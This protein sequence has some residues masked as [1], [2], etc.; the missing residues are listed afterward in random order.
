MANWDSI[1]KSDQFNSYTPEQQSVVR[2]GYFD[3]NIATNDTYKAFSPDQQQTVRSNWMEGFEPKRGVGQ[4]TQDYVSSLGK[5]L[6]GLGQLGGRAIDVAGNILPDFDGVEDNNI[7]DRA[8]QRIEQLYKG[9]EEMFTGKQSAHF[10]KEQE[11]TYGTGGEGFFAS[12]LGGEAWKSPEKVAGMVVESAPS[13]IL[14]MATGARTIQGLKGA[15]VKLSPWIMG[16]IGSAIGEGTMS[17][18]ETGKGIYDSMMSDEARDQFVTTPEYKKAFEETG[19]ETKARKKVAGAMA[20]RYGLGVGALTSLTGVVSGKFLDDIIGE[21]FKGNLAQA[22]AKGMA[23]EA[24]EEAVQSG[25]EQVAQ[26][27]IAGEFVDPKVK[28]YNELGEVMTSGAIAGGVMGAGIT[29]FFYKKPNGQLEEVPQAVREKISALSEMKQF[30]SIVQSGETQQLDQEMF[31]SVYQKAVTLQKQFPKDDNVSEAIATLNIER[32][33]RLAGM[34][35]QE[36]LD[37]EVND[38]MNSVVSGDER[39]AP[40]AEPKLS[41][42]EI[43]AQSIYGETTQIGTMA[44]ELAQKNTNI[45]NSVMN[46]LRQENPIF[47]PEEQRYFDQY[48]AAQEQVEK[49]Q[50]EFKKKADAV[51]AR[52]GIVAETETAVDEY[53]PEV[54]RPRS[55]YDPAVAE[56][57]KAQRTTE[58]LLEMPERGVEAVGQVEPLRNLSPEGEIAQQEYAKADEQLDPEITAIAITQA[59]QIARE[60]PVY[61]AIQDGRSGGMIN[62]ETLSQ[63]FAKEGL[64]NKYPFLFSNNGKLNID[65]F[66]SEQG[67]EDGNALIEDLRSAIPMNDEIKKIADSILAEQQVGAME[68]ADANIQERIKGAQGKV[69]KLA[70]LVDGIR[71][72]EALDNFSEQFKAQQAE[73]PELQIKGARRKINRAIKQKRYELGDTL[74]KQE[75]TTTEIKEKAQTGQAT[76]G[77]DG[78]GQAI[79]QEEADTLRKQVSDILPQYADEIDTSFGKISARE[80]EISSETQALGDKIAV[81]VS[82]NMPEGES[83]QFETEDEGMFMFTPV[84]GFW[85]GQE[86]TLALE[87]LS[88]EALEKSLENKREEYQDAEQDKGKRE[89]RTGVRQEDNGSGVLP[90]DTGKEPKQPKGKADSGQAEV[91]R[92]GMARP[93]DEPSG[94]KV[95]GEDGRAYILEDLAQAV[96]KSGMKFTEFASEIRKKLGKAYG[97]VRAKLQVIF[98][99]LSKPL[100]D[101]V[102]AVGKDVSISSVKGD[103]TLVALHNLSEQNILYAEDN[104]DGHLPVPSLAITKKETPLTDFGEISLIGDKDLISPSSESKVFGADAYTPRYPNVE[105]KINYEEFRKFS[106]T[107]EESAKK[108]GLG[109]YLDSSMMERDRWRDT[110]SRNI[111]VQSA[112]LDSIGKLPRMRMK[113]YSFPLAENNERLLT[114]AGQDP[115]ELASSKEFRDDIKLAYRNQGRDLPKGLSAGGF[116]MDALAHQASGYTKGK[117][118]DKASNRD[119]VASRMDSR[120]N[121]KGIKGYIERIGKDIIEGQQIFKGFNQAGSRKLYTPATLDNIVKI[122]KKNTR[123]GESFNYGLNSIKAMKTPQFK[124]LKAIK[125]NEDRLLGKDDFQVVWDEINDE[126]NDLLDSVEPQGISDVNDAILSASEGDFQY[127][128]DISKQD[129]AEFLQNLQDM[130]SKYFEVKLNR[131]VGI[132]EFS[133]AVVP[134][135]TSK[136]TISLLKDKGL[137]V[138]YYKKGDV[139]DRTRAVNLFKGQMFSKATKPLPTSQQADVTA[140]L[141]KTGESLIE[142][143]KL[144]VIS[145]AQLEAMTLEDERLKFAITPLFHG[146]PKTDIEKFS[147]DFAG[148]GGGQAFGHGVYFT[149]LQSVAEMYR[150]NVDDMD[151]VRSINAE[152][153][154]VLKAMKPYESGEYGKFTEQKGYDLKNKYDSLI[155]K[156]EKLL[157]KKG[158]VYQVEVA[159]NEEEFL[160]WDKPL[161]EQSDYIQNII[162]NNI[163]EHTKT[164]LGYLESN[165]KMIEAVGKNELTG[166]DFYILHNM[167]MKGGKKAVSEYFASIGIRGNKAT[168]ASREGSIY[169]LFDDS[170]IK[171][172]AKYS[173]DG[174]IEAFYDPNTD[175]TTLVQG[176]ISKGTAQNILA[177]EIGVHARSLGFNKTDDF[178]GILSMLNT[179]KDKQTAEGK[180]IRDAYDSVPAD[181]P[182][183]LINEEALAYLVNNSPKI[184]IVR[185]LIAK[186]KKFL[187]EH[188]FNADLLKNID[189]QALA[190]SVVKREARRVVEQ[191]GV[192]R[193]IT[194][195]EGVAFS[196]ADEGTPKEQQA[197]NNTTKLNATVDGVTSESSVEI[198]RKILKSLFKDLQAVSSPSVVESRF[199]KKAVAKSMAGLD[200]VM[201][202]MTDTHKSI[203]QKEQFAT[204]LSRKFPPEVRAKLLKSLKDIAQVK[205]DSTIRKRVNAFLATAN[206]ELKAHLKTE[207]A[208]KI[209]K[210]SKELK[211]PK[212]RVRKGRGAEFE[213]D[214]KYIR[215]EVLGLDEN[216]AERISDALAGERER[217][218]GKLK[219]A[220]SEAHAERL[221]KMLDEIDTKQ[222]FVDIFGDLIGEKRTVQDLALAYDTLRTMVKEN[223]QKWRESR[224]ALREHNKS[225]QENANQEITGQEEPVPETQ[226]ERKR[227]QEKQRE[228]I[229]RKFWY[230]QEFMSNGIQSWE[231][232]LDKVAKKSGKGVLGSWLVKH[233][234]SVAH[235][236]TRDKGDMVANSHEQI[237][238]K[239]EDVF[240]KNVAKAFAKAE[241]VH[242]DKVFFYPDGKKESVPLSEMEAG[243]IY[244]ISRGVNEDKSIQATFDSQG[245]T[246]ET[247]DQIDEFVSPEVKEWVHWAMDDFLQDFHTGI[248]EIYSQVEGIDLKKTPLYMPLRRE[249]NRNVESAEPT[250]ME[251][252]STGMNKAGSLKERVFNTNHFKLANFNSVLMNHVE[253]MSHYKAWALPTREINGTFNN[254][255]VKAYIEQYHGQDALK[256][257]QKF[258]EDFGKSILNRFDDLA[259]LDKLR[260][261]ITVAMVGANPIVMLKQLT[262]IPAMASDI[263][264]TDWVAGTSKFI[265]NPLKAYN[266]LKDN[267]PMFKQR[268]EKGFDKEM[269]NLAKDTASNAIAGKNKISEILM[270]GVKF[271]DKTAIAIGGYAVYNYYYNEATKSGKV[272]EDAIK[273]GIFKFEQAFERSQQSA[274]DQSRGWFLRGGSGMNLF[275]MF[276]TSPASY[277]RM[278]EMG[279]RHIKDDPKTASKMLIVYGVIL[280][281]VF[282]GVAD[283][284]LGIDGDDEEKEEFWNNQL[285]AVQIGYM[286][287]MPLLR[288]IQKGVL[289]TYDGNGWWSNSITPVE[290]MIDELKNVVGNA[291]KWADGGTDRI[292]ADEYRNR[293]FESVMH[294]AGYGSGIPTKPLQ[295]WGEGVVSAATGETERPIRASLGYSKKARGEKKNKYEKYMARVKKLRE[296]FD[297]ASKEDRAVIKKNPLFRYIKLAKYTSREIS[298]ANRLLKRQQAEG[299]DTTKT[300]ARIKLIQDKFT[301]KINL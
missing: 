256:T 219:V 20:T 93:T 44:D 214:L 95:T 235:T 281:M 55:P 257:I 290:S 161:S 260:A 169:V 221:E 178:K 57:M 301:G 109:G 177:H 205:R 204:T 13:T 295:R 159:P 56:T 11:K 296:E 102:G 217:V 272:E 244:A 154:D 61:R 49:G 185:Q 155:R 135:G 84:G 26:N 90:T 88:Q 79:T 47:T 121:Q 41:Q 151:A 46:K 81:D 186:I 16:L 97:D 265:A 251:S 14:G 184:T 277:S 269:A 207:L 216:G 148:K 266:F 293:T 271:G 229:P 198:G 39:Y 86:S 48:N 85:T 210:K 183:E 252:Q 189:M 107:V 188:G 123:G 22:I 193:D 292:N 66:A 72:L 119:A 17:G 278:I 82:N 227:R 173:K 141:G 6:A 25:V 197:I 111:A 103:D 74:G 225:N 117:S 199:G 236:A 138:R 270:S 67:Y 200:K 100:R 264:V 250:F 42:T 300:E 157:A 150:D 246:Q 274:N 259:I 9:R 126:F 125:K 242:D 110:L 51:R 106:D 21:K 203:A 261:N 122:M 209:I 254:P 162:K 233:M 40:P 73:Y 1:S 76:I 24:P 75:E 101:E 179:R 77:R 258:Q 170:D 62:L 181:T 238:G 50:A 35:Q 146:T 267:S 140:E 255:Q 92:Q 223:G 187:V 34:G 4:I 137:R 192:A 78:E 287:G 96:Y 156:R 243:Y 268:G 165:G 202:A 91:R 8:G 240:G 70:S 136:D 29:P 176:N 37:Y 220:T 228:S 249:V 297:V 194:Q 218:E 52:E 120:K 180:A 195:T 168:P 175:T 245:I 241:V 222:K 152:M 190:H 27:I 291:K 115:F 54:P 32:E 99:T 163:P 43:L 226:A 206:T 28:W 149:D 45:H 139:A 36:R 129:V 113:A 299:L 166:R 224:E 30:N 147:T 248:N 65:E 127:I 276:M 33:T 275:T 131:A 60:N 38:A 18:A 182:K 142:S 128:S 164:R 253:Q 196:K 201:E 132:D 114:Y 133:G 80:Q 282:Q 247:L 63:D 298:R 174:R 83:V 160:Q 116:R 134:K 280:P 23:L 68:L 58:N 215:E 12:F 5:G 279:A 105:N 172:E 59:E 153:S 286:N 31:D 211:L 284:M 98:D 213:N 231:T 167:N 171:I 143:G 69:E 118:I 2:G 3:S 263:P 112:Y 232:M 262:S 208:E 294:L 130:P 89:G 53:A 10:K 15:G 289:N 239:A 94:L 87:E 283:A 19:D 64:A 144:R 237:K 71:T 158:A 7:I 108:I 230:A 212:S 104:L 124:S 191:A 234:G 288:E 285:R 145:Q 273:E